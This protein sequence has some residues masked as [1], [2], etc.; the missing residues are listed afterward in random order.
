MGLGGKEY[1]GLNHLRMKCLR[2]QPNM[3]CW[4]QV[5]ISPQWK[6]MVRGQQ[7]EGNLLDKGGRSTGHETGSKQWRGTSLRWKGQG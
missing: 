3:V 5:A 4:G 2:W 6:S 1:C 7:A